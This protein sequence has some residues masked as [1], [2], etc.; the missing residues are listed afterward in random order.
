MQT[1]LLDWV[2][3]NKQTNDLCLPCS[4]FFFLV[5][6][7]V[8]MVKVIF[9]CN[10]SLVESTKDIKTAVYQIECIA[11]CYYRVHYYGIYRKRIL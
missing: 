10:V 7:F 11:I 3:T 8:Y 5:E 4:H 2:E 1:L 6:C 9:Q